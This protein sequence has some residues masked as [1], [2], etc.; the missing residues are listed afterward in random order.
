MVSQALSAQKSAPVNEHNPT[1]TQHHISQ[2]IV[3]LFLII[4]PPIAW[5]FMCKEKGYHG[6]FPIIILIY[7][8]IYIVSTVTLL[9]AFPQIAAAYKSHYNKEL[10]MPYDTIFIV[11]FCAIVEIIYALNIRKHA[12]QNG[13]LSKKKLI[14]AVS[15][16]TFNYLFLPFSLATIFFSL[17]AIILPLIPIK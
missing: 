17:M 5:Y 9:F 14:S 10:N 3:I 7:T 6:W 15:I 13:Q 11:M 16:L 8:F 12:K 4:F 2:W 1:I